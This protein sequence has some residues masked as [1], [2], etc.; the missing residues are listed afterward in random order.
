MHEVS[1]TVP[2]SACVGL[3]GLNGA[4]KSSL[5]DAIS[6]T[7]PA[8]GGVVSLFGE[9]VTRLP[10]WERARRGLV[11]MPARRQLWPSMSV[12]DTLLMG[13]YRRKDAA[14]I[15]ASMDRVFDLFP[16]LGERR[17][18]QAGTLSGGQQQMLALGRGLMADPRILL[19]DEPSEGLAPVI[20]TQM[21]D[22]IRAMQREAQ[23]TVL[24][25]EQNAGAI[26]LCSEVFVMRS[27][28]V[29]PLKDG[30][31]LSSRQI[32]ERVFGAEA[33]PN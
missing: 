31:D 32:A 24:L 13:A 23:I 22:A 1:L 16:I 15:A 8:R 25:A 12:L 19:L 11:Q 3:L 33:R 14:Q 4:G 5:L 2:S 6:G 26:A 7:L 10:A 21:F 18:Q 20:V 17:R 27:G 9:D 30:G 29:G 28:Y